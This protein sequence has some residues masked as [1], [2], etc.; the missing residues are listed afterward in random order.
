MRAASVAPSEGAAGV[1]SVEPVIRF[2]VE[3]LVASALSDEI[4]FGS[5]LAMDESA[6]I[7]GTL[8]TSIE[9]AVTTAGEAD[10]L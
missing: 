1:V 8:A 10:A 7:A 3:L 5:E 2:E 9:V 4:C 6:T